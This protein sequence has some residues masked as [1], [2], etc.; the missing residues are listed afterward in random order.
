MTSKV[1]KLEMNV[2]PGSNHPGMI[3]KNNGVFRCNL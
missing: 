1:N 3:Y 2:S